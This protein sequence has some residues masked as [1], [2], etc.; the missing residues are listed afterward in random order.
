MVKALIILITHDDI[1]LSLLSYQRVESGVFLT[2]QWTMMHGPRPPSCW[3]TSP[4]TSIIQGGEGRPAWS[5]GPYG[6]PASS[7]Q[8]TVSGTVQYRV[9]W[10]INC[11]CL[12]IFNTAAPAPDGDHPTCQSGELLPEWTSACMG[13]TTHAYACMHALAACYS[14]LS[15]ILSHPLSL[16]HHRGTLPCPTPAM[17]VSLESLSLSLSHTHTR[18]HTRSAQLGVGAHSDWSS[19]CASSKG[20]DHADMQCLWRVSMIT[21]PTYVVLTHT[22]NNVKQPKVPVYKTFGS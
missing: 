14:L 9:V 15:S 8:L 11:M 17:L 4:S 10:G 3:P 19:A 5:H 2:V 20:Q 1:S 13:R 16:S 7:T 12:V 18:T 6:L 22:W 21:K